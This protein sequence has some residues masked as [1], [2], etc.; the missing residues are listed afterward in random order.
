MVKNVVSTKWTQ[1]S[2]FETDNPSGNKFIMFD[3]SQDNGDVVGFA[4]KFHYF[5]EMIIHIHMRTTCENQMKQTCITDEDFIGEMKKIM[6]GS[7]F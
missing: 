3:K 1:K 2:Q 7:C 6:M 5:D 4:P